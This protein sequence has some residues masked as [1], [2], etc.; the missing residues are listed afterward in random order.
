[1]NGRW[2]KELESEELLDIIFAY[3]SRITIENNLNRLLLL[4]AD[5]GRD[6]TVADRCM[7]WLYDEPKDELW[8]KVEE[9]T[10]E[11]RIPAS[12][13]LAGYVFQTAEPLVIEDAYHDDRFHADMDLMYNYRTKSVMVIPLKNKQNQTLGVYQVINKLTKEGVFTTHDVKKLSLAASYT[14]QALE[15]VLMN[16]EME[17][18]QKE[19][20]FKMGEI[21]EVRSKETGSHVKRVAEYAKLLAIKSGLSEEE[22]D[23]IKVASPMHDIGKVAIADAILNKPGKLS[24]QEFLEV[25]AHAS[26]GYH[27]LENSKRTILKAAA[28]IA[29]EHHERWDGKGYPEGLSGEEI[30][31][32]GR[33]VA[34]ADVFDALATDRP[35]K[36]AWDLE[37]ILT[38][39]QNEKGKQFDP[40]LIDVFLEN[41]HGFLQIK[42]RYED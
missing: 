25:Q 37:D 9:R 41:L 4:M 6:M 31:I 18:A 27:L 42:K 15:A 35:Y 5:M 40:A 13:G 39:F 7:L 16:M 17:E 34:V 12:S 10:K 23:L 11:V 36:K 14:A 32:Y 28:I 30:H 33:I 24:K 8:A 3:A 38:H 29:K 22:A 1:M 26:I 19:I 21:G 2:K 20:I